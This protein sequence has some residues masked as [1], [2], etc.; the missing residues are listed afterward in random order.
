MKHK[1]QLGGIDGWQIDGK[2]GVRAPKIPAARCSGCNAR[3]TTTFAC[4]ARWVEARRP[5]R[6]TGQ[7]SLEVANQGA[8]KRPRQRCWKNNGW[9]CPSGIAWWVR[10]L[11]P[12]QQE[13]LS[14]N[15]DSR[16]A[17][18]EQDGWQVESLRRNKAVTGCPSASSCTA[19]T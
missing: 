7:V 2:V 6:A 5:D 3:I 18:L 17:T 8:M 13:R 15:S 11:P 1:A 14:L 16:L 19:P 9:K 4:P 10:G 12:Q